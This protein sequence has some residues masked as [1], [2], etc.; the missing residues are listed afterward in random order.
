[1]RKNRIRLTESQLHRVIKESVK[2]VLREGAKPY[3]NP[4]DAMKDADDRAWRAFDIGQEEPGDTFSNSDYFSNMS[5]MD[6]VDDIAE[7]YGVS[8]KRAM[9]M[10][11]GQMNSWSKYFQENPR[12]EEEY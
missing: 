12:D 9:N 6:A 7:R 4:K 10:L 8:S 11:I 2:R 5:I 3:A 1:M